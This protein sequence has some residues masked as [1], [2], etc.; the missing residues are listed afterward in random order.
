MLC[1]VPSVSSCGNLA[2]KRV[3]VLGALILLR[4]SFEHDIAV[5]SLPLDLNKNG[6]DL[7]T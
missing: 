4:L 7:E 3:V 2:H 6:T 1:G 5:H